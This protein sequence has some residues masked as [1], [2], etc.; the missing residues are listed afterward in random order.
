MSVTHHL[1]TVL[2]VERGDDQEIDAKTGK[3][4]L[5]DIVVTTPITILACRCSPD[6]TALPAYTEELDDGWGQ[7]LACPCKDRCPITTRSS[8]FTPARGIDDL[9]PNPVATYSR[10]SPPQP[11]APLSTTG[12]PRTSTMNTAEV[13]I[14]DN[15]TRPSVRTLTTLLDRNCQF[16]RL[17]SGQESEVG[18]APPS[19]STATHQSR[20][21][22]RGRVMVQEARNSGPLLEY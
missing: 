15:A 20:S 13:N 5:F 1:K 8:I 22:S 10:S 3:R 16:E 11:G 18:E 21:Q 6:W 17:M 12:L 9:E 7:P 19:Y 4:K 2:R 14:L